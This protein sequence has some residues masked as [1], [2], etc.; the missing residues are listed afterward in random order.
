MIHEPPQLCTPE[1]ALAA[2]GLER[3]CQRLAECPQWAHRLGTFLEEASEFSARS[4]RLQA[5]F[6]LTARGLGSLG[7]L[8][9][10]QA[11]YAERLD[12]LML[13]ELYEGALGCDFEL[14]RLILMA[15]DT[16][17]SHASATAFAPDPVLDAVSLG[18]RKSMARKLD[19]DLME[20]LAKDG[21]ARVI[22]IYLAN[23]RLT[24]S[25][26]LRMI[27]LR[28]HRGKILREFGVQYR[29]LSRPQV[30][31]ALVLNPY[32]PIRLAMLLAPLLGDVFLREATQTRNLHPALKR[33]VRGLLAIRPHP[34]Y[35]DASQDGSLTS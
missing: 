17:H 26:V 23:P 19:P 29:W 8:G 11:I 14:I 32:T 20:R 5:L 27:A 25:L 6:E 31:R 15:D 24:E 7:W 13:K 18:E 2:R 10:V 35:F 12:A 30:R 3:D 28:P 33:L 16:G 22:R 34:S 4:D 21:D 9:L 1:S